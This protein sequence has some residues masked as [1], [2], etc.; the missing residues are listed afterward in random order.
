M[1]KDFGLQKRRKVLE[2][3]E[4]GDQQDEQEQAVV[5]ENRVG[6][7]LEFGNLIFLPQST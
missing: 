1:Q 3:Q 4:R 5:V 7:G 2:D 6:G